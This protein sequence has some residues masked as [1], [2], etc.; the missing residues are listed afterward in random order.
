MPVTLTGTG[1]TL[2]S[3]GSEIIRSIVPRAIRWTSTVTTPAAVTLNSQADFYLNM[4]V[5][6]PAARDANSRFLIFAKCNVDDTN[7]S[8][9]GFGLSI[10]VEQS[11]GN[12]NQQWVRRQGL[13]AE[14]FNTGADKYYNQHHMVLDV[15]GSTGSSPVLRANDQRR[16]RVYGMAN[17]SNCTGNCGV[18]ATT[19]ATGMLMVIEFD[20]KVLNV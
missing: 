18:N 2:G 3:S 15:P 11:N 13:H 19:N 4:Q 10:W 20:G 5:I 8:T 17:N 7:S 14:Y 12:G 6:M 1:I 9:F 16:Y